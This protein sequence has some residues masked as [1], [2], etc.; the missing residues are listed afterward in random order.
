MRTA[1]AILALLLVLLG[2]FFAGYGVL[3]LNKANVAL[4]PRELRDIAIGAGFVL[5]CLVSLLRGGRSAR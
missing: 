1:L 3:L 4:G 5:F 2:A